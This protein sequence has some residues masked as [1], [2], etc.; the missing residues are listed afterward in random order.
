MTVLA[1]GVDHE[2]NAVRAWALHA[3][4]TKADAKPRRVCIT[5]PCRKTDRA[6]DGVLPDGCGQAAL[7]RPARGSLRM[8]LSWHG[9]QPLVIKVLLTT[10]WVLSVAMVVVVFTTL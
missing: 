7:G 3:A 5:K 6:S 10:G 8:F 9:K 2:T 4:L 1:C